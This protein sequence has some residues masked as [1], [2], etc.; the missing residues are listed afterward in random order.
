[1]AADDSLD[2]PTGSGDDPT[3]PRDGDADEPRTVSAG[4]GD[5]RAPW[6]LV[7]RVLVGLEAIVPLAFAGFGVVQLITGGS[8]VQRNEAML[9]VLSFIT[10]MALLFVAYAVGNGRRAVRT[11]SLVWQLLLL[12]IVWN[13]WQAHLYAWS[14]GVLIL[15]VLA[16]YATVRA[17]ADVS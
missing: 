2:P 17:T 7:A 10:G 16:G 12:A 14:L 6:Q 9:V 8:I 3:A 13:M 11:A 1:M 5:P 15:A 4:G